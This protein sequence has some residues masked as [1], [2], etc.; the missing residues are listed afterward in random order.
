MTLSTDIIIVTANTREMTL[1]CLA[2]VAGRVA[3]HPVV[4]DNGSTDGTAEAVR[5]SFA[6]A[7]VLELD[8]PVGF[9]A[10]CNRGAALGT[11]PLVLFLNSDVLASDGAVDE[12]IA[13]LVA[14]P[15]A[16]AAG[17]RLVDPGTS[18][19]QKRYAPQPFPSAPDFARILLGL[20]PRSAPPPPEDRT[21]EVDQPAG[22]CL[23]ARRQDFEAVGGFDESFWFWY[24]DVD[25]CRRLRE[26]GPL[27][28][29]PTAAFEHLGGG[30]FAQWS[31][32]QSTA[33]LLHGMLR[34]AEKHF[35]RRQSIGFGLLLLVH[36]GLRAILGTGELRRIHKNAVRAALGLLGGRPTASLAH[37]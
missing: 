37:H 33:S 17:G 22:A 14:H 18:T 19:T 4:V 25:L 1:S 32:A 9:A 28:N 5:A 20:G 12:L 30:T 8:E 13:E 16:V 15:V 34:Y 21:V 27:L 29:V 24:E 11:S 7:T 10:A 35:S 3:T 31:E 26:I 6:D 2:R 36:S 23:L